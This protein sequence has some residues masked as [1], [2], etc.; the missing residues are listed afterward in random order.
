MASKPQIDQIVLTFA[1]N[2]P[3]FVSPDGIFDQI[4]PAPGTLGASAFGDYFNGIVDA[5]NQNNV[6]TQVVDADLRGAV[7]W[8]D[9]SQNLFVRQG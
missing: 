4:T 6:N 3:I 9:V 2:C 5:M 7:I 1:R 8:D